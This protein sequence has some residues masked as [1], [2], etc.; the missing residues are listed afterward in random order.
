MGRVRMVPPDWAHLKD[1]RDNYEPLH[2]GYAQA[3]KSSRRCA[4]RTALKRP[5]LTTAVAL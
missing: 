5:L 1:Y 3:C 2:M 4:S